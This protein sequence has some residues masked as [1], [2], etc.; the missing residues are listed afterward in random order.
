MYGDYIVPDDDI[1]GRLIRAIQF[2]Y[3]EE[4]L[5]L[6]PLLEDINEKDSSV[7]EWTPLMYS[8]HQESLDMVKALVKAG[9]GVNLR[10]IEMDE[11]AL[12]LAAYGCCAASY[13]YEYTR[14]KKIY[15]YLFPLTSPE[16]QQIAE[17]TLNSRTNTIFN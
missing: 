13:G 6:L 10:G 11:F 9:A 14:N 3:L 15:D 7:L 12:N 1:F 4:F 5:E 17:E 2:G 16:L 8:V